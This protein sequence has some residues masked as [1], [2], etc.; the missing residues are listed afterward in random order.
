MESS[1][2][3][4][5]PDMYDG[6]VTATELK[7]AKEQE[8]RK[9]DITPDLS[10]KDEHN[11]INIFDDTDIEGIYV[12]CAQYGLT[13]VEKSQAM[14]YT[15]YLIY[16]LGVVAKDCLKP[17]NV[18]SRRSIKISHVEGG[19]NLIRDYKYPY[20]PDI[21]KLEP[22]SDDTILSIGNFKCKKSDI[23][24][25]SLSLWAYSDGI[26]DESRNF[27]S[28]CSGFVLCVLIN[29]SND[30]CIKLIKYMKYLNEKK[31]IKKVD[32]S[33]VKP[34]LYKASYESNFPNTHN[35]EFYDEF[36]VSKQEITELKTLNCKYNVGK[37][38]VD[39][40]LGF[41]FIVTLYN[42][43]KNMTT[44]GFNN[45][46]S[47]MFKSHKVRRVGEPSLFKKS[48]SVNKSKSKSVNKSKSKS[49]SKKSVNK[50]KS[51]K[52]INKSKSKSKKYM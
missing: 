36:K 9:K 3:R 25:R 28:S 16:C 39:L 43:K 13:N 30:F 2:K 52:S 47:K 33:Q 24:K 46:K 37:Y 41:S 29:V 10:I 21:T 22:T 1:R 45:L 27:P 38:N 31:Y 5:Q 12:L 18:E 50:S 15:L 4:K 49:K 11:K 8:E 14:H 40:D 51:K 23:Y 44:S 42:A 35:I 20:I 32:S 48:K 19:Y 26:F 6:L 34:A 17:E 7:E